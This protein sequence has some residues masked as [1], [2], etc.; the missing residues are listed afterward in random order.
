MLYT[1]KL[2]NIRFTSLVFPLC[3]RSKEDAKRTS[4]GQLN[5]NV[6]SR[7]DCKQQKLPTLVANYAYY[8]ELNLFNLN[9]SIPKTLMGKFGVMHKAVSYCTIAGIGHP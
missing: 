3:K 5:K 2:I 1:F 8:I 4:Y 6:E 7:T 9:E